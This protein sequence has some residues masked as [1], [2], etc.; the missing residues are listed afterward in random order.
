MVI[1][2]GLAIVPILL[3][4]IMGDVQIDD[5]KKK[6]FLFLCGLCIAVIAGL[7]SKYVGTT[8]TLNYCTLYER[9]VR[10]SSLEKF[11]K[12]CNVL[13]K[14]LLV[15]ECLFYSFTFF[16]AKLFPET[17]FFIL[18]TTMIITYSVMRFI[19]KH[20]HE[21]VLSVVMYV[22]L[23][24]LTFNMNGMRQALAMSICLF[25]FDFAKEKKLIPFLLIVLLAMLVH[26]TA[27]FFAIVYFVA[28]FKIDW[29]HMMLFVISIIAFLLLA[30]RLAQ[31][32]DGLTDKN[33]SDVGAFETGGVVTVLIYILTIA[34]SLVFGWKNRK[35]GGF[36]F[37]IYLTILGL[38]LYFGRYI[39]TQIYERMSY[40]FFYA[41][42]LLL[43]QA[44]TML[45]GKEKQ[46]SIVVVN[47]LSILLFIYRL[48]GSVFQ[49]FSFFWG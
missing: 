39:S 8:D 10:Y 3:R 37:A 44:V 17:Q 1:L 38:A 46:V 25:A 16:C 33:Y 26:K 9:A 29:K 41:V 36:S 19:Y 23:G 21:V 31:I 49:S 7:R 32:F 22:C 14:G 20:S 28:Q 27:I 4:W 15:S 48:Y 42:L 6:W 12:S 2:V 45:K 35:D 5:K 13:E 40:Y 34:F 43:P 24:L 47:C 30:D 18:I 11:L